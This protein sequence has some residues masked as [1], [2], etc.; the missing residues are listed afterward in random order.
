MKT[1]VSL[2]TALSG[3]GFAA[4]PPDPGA[5][6]EGLTESEWTDI[7][8]AHEEAR[9]APERQENGRL[10]A[11]NPGQQ[12]SAEFDG[13]GFTVT[14]DQGDWTWGLDLTGY[15]DRTL[16]YPALPSQLRQETGKITCQR[17]ENLT[18]WFINDRRGLEQGWDLKQRP[19]RADPAAPLTLHLVTRGNVLPQVSSS[20]DSVSFLEDGGG[21][22]LT[23]GGL[24]AWDAD[25]KK[26]AVRFEEAGEKSLRIAIE[27]LGA[28]YPITIDPVAR[29]NYLQASNAR[30]YNLFGSAV[31][32]HGDTVVV[33]APG[34]SS[35][36]TGVNGD[37]TNTSMPGSGAVF[38]F[39]RSGMGWTQQAYLKASNSAFNDYFGNS[40]TLE[41]DTLVVGAIGEDSAATGV[42]GDQ[43]SNAALESGAVYIFTRSGTTWSQQAYVKASNTGAGDAFSYALD[44]SG[45][46]LVVGAYGEASIA[47]GVN[48]DQADNSCPISGAAYIF[49][50]NGTNWEQQAYLKASNTDGEDY[51]GLAAA[52]SGDTVVVGAFAEDSPSTGVNGPGGNSVGSASSGAAYIFVRNGTTWTHEAYL[53][54]SNTGQGDQFGGE[55]EISG[56]T[57]LVA[58]S[59]EDSIATGVNG[60]QT[61]NQATDAGAG[62]V[63]VRSGTTWTQ[64]AYLKASN[65]ER[66]SNFGSRDYFGSSI[67]MS[68]NKVAIGAYWEDSNATGVNGNQ[69][70]NNAGESG[71]IYVFSRSGATWSQHAYIK[72]ASTWQLQQFGSGIGFSGETIVSGVRTPSNETGGVYVTDFFTTPEISIDQAGANV[73]NGTTKSL[74]TTAMGDANEMVFDVTNFGES[75]LT[76]T[77]LPKVAVTAG[78]DFSVTTQPA[79]PIAGAGGKTT[80]KVRFAPTGG[81]SRAGTISI[82]NSDAGEPSYLIHLSG[83]G[84][85]FTTDTDGDGL[86][87]AAE[88]KMAALN[89]DW[90][91]SQAALVD[92]YFSQAP[93]AGLRTLAQIQAL[94]PGTP[95]ITKDPASGRFKLLTRWEKSTNLANFVNFPAPVDSSVSISPSGG[96]ELEFA[97]PD[98][99][100]FFRIGQD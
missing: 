53:K 54:A 68:G 36:A 44:L 30:A 15:G 52:V 66:Q 29:Q 57:V 84:L 12:W 27:D 88:F 64:E 35:N 3:L 50:R 9:H 32:V 90:Q 7:Q 86:N 28:R 8:A 56:D 87:D 17:D 94:H 63:F 18:E 85:S 14:P 20:G 42:N 82:P 41:G 34:E 92:A 72:P 93:G 61:D 65:T 33:G 13:S 48:G 23:Y 74:G 91:V 37:Q 43:T 47:S 81:G 6:P 73:A 1:L 96:V 99:A 60:N 16:P 95:L 70:N 75:D 24:K 100:A 26:L 31:A 59:C 40:L 49:V 2:L 39:V 19:E 46:T 51:F 77:G 83:T 11:R 21:S 10:L 89:F 5:T 25:G 62:Y 98:N 71:A 97:P 22:V 80:F 55:V 79:S 78:S 38:V 58:A 4:T 69:N 76:L 67:A 45:D